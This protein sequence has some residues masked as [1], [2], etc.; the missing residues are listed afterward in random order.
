MQR[1]TSDISPKKLPPKL[2]K[3]KGVKFAADTQGGTPVEKKVMKKG[4]TA[5]VVTRWYRAPEVILM[6]DFYSAAIDIWSV[7]CMLAE[8]LAMMKENYATVF[9]RQPLFPGHSC[10][11]LSPRAAKAEE[12]K[13]L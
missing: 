12:D 7:V 6:A 5:H 10:F 2:A 3:T 13:D 11:P 4:L 1:T 8:M 9:D